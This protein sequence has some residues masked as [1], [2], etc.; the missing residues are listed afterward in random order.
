MP[1]GRSGASDHA[2]APVREP[3]ILNAI[4]EA[5]NSSPDELRAL[6]RTLELVAEPVRRLM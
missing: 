5:L 3:R 1:E 2:D 6:E 4:A